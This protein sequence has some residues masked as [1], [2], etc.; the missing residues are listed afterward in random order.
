M[1]R[2]FRLKRNV[3]RQLQHGPR[4]DAAPAPFLVLILIFIL[5]LTLACGRPA[6]AQVCGLCELAGRIDREELII[7]VREL[8]G[9]DSVTVGGTRTRIRTRAT[10]LPEKLVARDYLLE[11]V[12]EL[13]YSALRQPF[14]L[15]VYYPDLLAAEISVTGETLWTGSDEGEVYMMTAAEG[16]NTARVVSTIDA[17]IYDL[18]LD[19]FGTL[20]AACKTIGAGLGEL[21][22]SDDGGMT[23]QA[24]IIGDMANGVQAL[25][26]IVF[27]S[28]GAAIVSGSFGTAFRMQYAMGDW[29]ITYYFDPADFYYRQLNGSSSSGPMHIWIVSVGGTIFESEDLGATWTNTTP[30]FKTLWD[31]DFSGPDRGIA[32]GE[33]VTYH[34][35][36]GGD[37]WNMVAVQSSL[38][39][40][41]ML[42]SLRAV[43]AG[44][45][46]DVWRTEDGGATWSPVAY[47]CA[48]DEDIRKTVFSPSDTIWAVGRNMPLKLELGGT[49]PVCR[50]WELADTLQGENIIFS[51]E[52]RTLPDEKIVVCA[53]YD[54]RNW[55]DP[56][57]APGA[58]DNASGCAG[59][60]E[61]ARIFA[62]ASFD[63]SIEYILFDGE[64][65]GLIGSRHYVAVRDTGLTIGG[66]IN[67]DMIGRDYG[68]GVTVQVAGRADPLVS[69]LAALI[70][71]MSAFLQLDLD[72]EYL[73]NYSPTSDHKPF[74]D[75]AGVPAILLIEDEYYNNPHYHACSDVADNID[76]D[77]MTDIV[78]GTAGSAAQLAGLISADPLPSSVVLHQ[79][80]PNPLINH[81]Q[82]RFEL[83]SRLPVD[84]TLFDLTGRQ[85]VVMITDT[86][87]EGRHEYA[88]DG[89]RSSGEAVASG[90]YFLRLK[91][92]STDC[93]RKV[94]IIR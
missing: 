17:R 31:I 62:D 4:I 76:F 93:V 36:D 19:D 73:Y 57:C 83:P 37:T 41:T 10:L 87:D 16:W 65:T 43:T 28:P 68:G 13:G 72:C 90:V 22:Y 24:K 59:V 77:Y 92:G 53:H 30:G 39:S 49:H 45:G 56:Y 20:W 44:G 86:L 1:E 75:I 40:V 50:Q 25:S 85:V 29:L 23:W 47:D 33:G 69:A 26:S 91:A 67:L 70:I 63:R 71:D 2:K 5:Q 78:K 54:S 58:D 51:S 84:L 14:T 48:R 34:T 6:S 82:I 74:W 11:R 27:S 42:D 7:T 66:V 88:W 81:T 15:S 61:I 3:T 38:F 60:L 18:E 55:Q 9:A 94:V 8:S 32:V 35:S 52:G 46:G 89:R 21:H 79:N 80:F 64:E 12:A